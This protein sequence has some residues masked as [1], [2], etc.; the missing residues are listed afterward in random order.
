[1]S[2]V[3][4]R[5]GLVVGQLCAEGPTDSNARAQQGPNGKA[6]RVNI[7]I[8]NLKG[9]GRFVR[10]A[11][12]EYIGRPNRLTGRKGSVLAN[13]FRIGIDGTRD[14]CVDKYEA[15][16]RAQIAMGRRAV[17]DELARLASIAV[18]TGKLTMACFCDVPE[19]RC[20]GQVI[21]KA[22]EEVL[23]YEDVG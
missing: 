6:G 12:V 17:L 1:L 7:S 8:I 14:E 10:P 15:W 21:A 11:G 3:P 18:R 23:A 13:P 5:E 22:L 4:Q 16:L 20:H 9:H 2:T 19:Q